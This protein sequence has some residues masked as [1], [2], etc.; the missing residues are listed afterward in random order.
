MLSVFLCEHQSAGALEQKY[1]YTTLT[2]LCAK[3]DFLPGA[4]KK[5]L[6]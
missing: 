6:C 4:V 5:V 3:Y 2:Q 1:V